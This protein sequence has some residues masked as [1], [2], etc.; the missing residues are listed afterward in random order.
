LRLGFCFSARRAGTVQ[1]FPVNK[2]M[3][4]LN[5][6]ARRQSAGPPAGLSSRGGLQPFV[7]YLSASPQ[8]FVRIAR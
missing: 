4:R 2:T 5:R 6:R 3:Q 7:S 1:V 8:L